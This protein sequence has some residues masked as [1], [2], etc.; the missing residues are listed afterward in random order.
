MRLREQ[1]SS[2]QAH[3]SFSDERCKELSRLREETNAERLRAQEE[4]ALALSAARAAEE[5][6]AI[7]A[8]EHRALEDSLA[9]LEA[10]RRE[11]SADLLM[12]LERVHTSNKELTSEAD[13]L[14]AEHRRV[15]QALN[16]SAARTAELET[17]VGRIED[18]R[19]RIGAQ[20]LT[21]HASLSQPLQPPPAQR[22]APIH[23]TSSMSRE[24][25]PQG[26][27]GGRLPDTTSPRLATPSRV[28]DTPGWSNTRRDE[29]PPAEP[30]TPSPM[31]AS[32]GPS[33]HG[34]SS[35]H[36]SSPHMQQMACA[37]TMP[38][39]LHAHGQAMWAVVPGAHPACAAAPATVA[40][41]AAAASRTFPAELMPV[42]SAAAGSVPSRDAR[43]SSCW[44]QDL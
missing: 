41:Q 26:Q 4:S 33:S 43:S 8:A 37:H 10:S 36:G 19:R 32:H 42:G 5:R 39:V 24:E 27:A 15:A 31:A 40:A 18:E 29:A 21:M 3:A 12:R 1:L 35:L 38:P 22:P 11:E 6:L 13:A 9:R 14:R 2:V 25:I 28:S 16:T 20:L 30:Y 34:P 44:L 7:A 23:N 17:L